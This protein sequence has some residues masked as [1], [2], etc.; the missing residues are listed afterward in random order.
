M[1]SVYR[2][3]FELSTPSPTV[4][5]YLERALAGYQ[6]RRVKQHA[7]G[8]AI[9]SL[10]VVIAVAYV[11]LAKPE[12]G[13]L[14]TPSGLLLLP[15]A[16]GIVICAGMALDAQKLPVLDQLRTGIAIRTVRRDV[17]HIEVRRGVVRVAKDIPVVLVDFT[18]GKTMSVPSLGDAPQ[19]KRIEELLRKQQEQQASRAHR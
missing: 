1:A 6:R 12:D 4:N 2:P 13:W 7:I 15:G 17:R 19:L 10:A 5:P 11:L 3:D 18:D 16:I 9:S 8:L 14:C